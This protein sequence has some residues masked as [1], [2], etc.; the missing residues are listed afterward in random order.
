MLHLYYNATAMV[1][2]ISTSNIK[3]L[4]N[5]LVIEVIKF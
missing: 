1:A 3:L 4:S 5:L 2:L